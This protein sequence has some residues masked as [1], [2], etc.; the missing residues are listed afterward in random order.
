MP[1]SNLVQAD[2]PVGA[3]VLAPVG[4]APGFSVDAFTSSSVMD[5]SVARGSPIARGEP[6]RVPHAIRPPRN[7]ERE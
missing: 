3:D 6:A 7:S 4:T 2:L 5:A 1:E